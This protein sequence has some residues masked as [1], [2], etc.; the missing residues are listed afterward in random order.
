MTK[1]LNR[2]EIAGFK[3]IRDIDLEL[4]PV[5]ILLGGNGAGKS[6]ML[7]A[8]ELLRE[9]VEMRL[10]VY[11]ARQGGASSLLHFGPRH[12]PTMTLALHFQSDGYMVKLAA[13]PGDRLF[14]EEENACWWDE[15]RNTM[16]G[17]TSDGTSSEGNSASVAYES[18]LS[19]AFASRQASAS[20]AISQVMPLM[21][22]W[23]RYHFHDTS[24][25]ARIKL[26]HEIDDN[27]TLRSDASNLAAFLY[28]LQ[29]I[30]PNA[31]RKIVATVRMVAPFF[32]DFVLRP[33][34]VRED[35]ILLQWRHKSSDDYFNAHSLSDGTLRF[36]CLA[37]LLL[38][39]EL[40]ATILI[41]EPEIG[42]HPYAIHQLAALI[43]SA[44]KRSQIIAATQSVTFM[45]HFDAEDIVITEHE[46]AASTFRRVNPIE[47][48]DWLEAY[49]LGELWEKNVLGGR[50]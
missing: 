25:S 20:P 35:K 31:Y 13:A 14:I 6:N 18:V 4:R 43:R 10:Q 40:P 1:P 16:R 21:Q 28:K 15:D 7:G 2:I 19:T 9:I 32:H 29:R 36:M 23:Q 3:S 27:H 48:S 33:D 42:L 5:N 12:T 22:S 46:D 37:T 17:S 49:T 30:H 11:T 34:P 50:P 45:N 26:K 44:S 41:D 39:P 38:Q 8:F 47:L 24:A